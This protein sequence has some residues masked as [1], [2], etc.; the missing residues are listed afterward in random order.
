M[1]PT[2]T[3]PFSPSQKYGTIFSVL[4]DTVGGCPNERRGDNF[5]APSREGVSRMVTYE[6]LFAFCL[7]LLGVAELIFQF[8][9]KK[10]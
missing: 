9:N 5:F 4:P 2:W 8:Y 7:V 3:Y 6:G 10:K 1:C